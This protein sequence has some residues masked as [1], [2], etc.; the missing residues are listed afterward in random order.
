MERF[1]ATNPGLPSRFTK[2][3]RFESYTP[4][5]L[6]AI[7]QDLARRDGL[8]IAAKADPPMAEFFAR[9]AGTPGFGN[10]RT[11]RTLLERA[12]EA[13][14]TRLAPELGDPAPISAC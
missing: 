1:L 4:R 9:A 11:A 12:R 5:E 14:A 8:R 2:T 6:V 10:A 3:V 13:Q 7:T